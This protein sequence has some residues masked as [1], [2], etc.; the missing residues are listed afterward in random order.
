[1]KRCQRVLCALAMLVMVSGTATATDWGLLVGVS[2]YPELPKDKW[3]RGPTNDVVMMTKLLCAEPFNFDPANITT[4]SGWPKDESK[5]PTRANIKSAFE[6]LAKKVKK[7]DQVV[8]AMS[9]HGSQQPDI[10]QSGDIEPDGL[11]E[12]FLPADA[13]GWDPKPRV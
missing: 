13:S 5:R 10:P 3:L 4:L 2:D 11:D 9:G 6:A 7:G 12:I 1:M 8:I